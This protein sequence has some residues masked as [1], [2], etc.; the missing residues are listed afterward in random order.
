MAGRRRTWR[1]SERS[2]F[3]ITTTISIVTISRIARNTRA[4][5]RAD[6]GC[7]GGG[8]ECDEGEG[9]RRRS[10]VIIVRRRRR[11]GEGA[12]PISPAGELSHTNGERCCGRECTQGQCCCCCFERVPFSKRALPRRHKSMGL[13]RGKNAKEKGAHTK[14]LAGAR[15]VGDVG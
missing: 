11:L 14:A 8:G 15:G 13:G 9:R 10:G 3:T 6:G 1:R 2:S 4:G 5:G 12:F 7:G